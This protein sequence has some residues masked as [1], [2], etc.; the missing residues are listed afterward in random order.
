MAKNHSDLFWEQLSHLMMPRCVLSGPA[1]RVMA[2]GVAGLPGLPELPGGVARWHH[3]LISN[4]PPP[5][6]PEARPS[7]LIRGGKSLAKRRR[8]DNSLFG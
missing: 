3:R 6:G 2:K 4:D 7:G 8:R 5:S 1:G